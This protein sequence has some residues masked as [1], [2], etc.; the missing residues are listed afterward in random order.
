M[1]FL[2]VGPAE[3][4][5]VI[6]ILLVVVGPER[7]PEIGQ[8]MGKA[9]ARLMA[10]QVQSPEY[11][12]VHQIHQDMQREI[13][14]LRDEIIRTRQQIASN[15]QPVQEEM[16]SL[17]R[18]VPATIKA[19]RLK[20]GLNNPTAA[21]KEKEPAETT[22]ATATPPVSLEKTTPPRQQQHAQGA[23]SNNNNNEVAELRREMEQTR[24]QLSLEIEHLRRE[25]SELKKR[26]HAATEHLEL[27]HEVGRMGTAPAAEN[28]ATSATT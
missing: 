12:T 20:N 27:E 21:Q 28:N 14:D 8:F 9:L 11:Q 10:W 2:G 4:I 13:V 3:F 6:L 18:T 23:T 16:R 1:D 5:F 19:G 22:P 26:L 24:D 25:V 7:L 17:Q 15:V